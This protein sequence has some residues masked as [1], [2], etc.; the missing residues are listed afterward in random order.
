MNPLSTL[1]R[2]V[3]HVTTER[4]NVV[5]SRT[6]RAGALQ[7]V[8]LLAMTPAACQQR[9]TKQPVEHD[10]QNGK[11]RVA[12]ERWVRASRE[13]DRRNH[14]HFHPDDREGEDQR[15]VGLAQLDGEAIGVTHHRKRRKQKPAEEPSEHESGLPRAREIAKPRLAKD[16][17]QDRRA[18]AQADGPLLAQR[19][20]SAVRPTRRDPFSCVLVVCSYRHK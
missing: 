3:V 8:L 2:P 6:W 18:N 5:A 4:S 17:K 13:H 10:H 19:D 9:E 16:R 20:P 14:H 7:V 15:S 1:V 12:R 11:H